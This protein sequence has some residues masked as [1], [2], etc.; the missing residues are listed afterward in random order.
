MWSCFLSAG[1]GLRSAQSLTK[2]NPNEMSNREQQVNYLQAR[3][4]FSIVSQ[5]KT[6]GVCV[7]VCFFFFSMAWKR[8]VRFPLRLQSRHCSEMREEQTELRIKH[9]RGQAVGVWEGLWRGGCSVTQVFWQEHSF[10]CCMRWLSNELTCVR[11]LL[12]FD[13]RFSSFLNSGVTAWL[14]ICF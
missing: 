6:W 13:L 8:E 2:L 10:L 12:W 1:P 11:H 7:C 3:T 4:R 14:L 9:S 5:R